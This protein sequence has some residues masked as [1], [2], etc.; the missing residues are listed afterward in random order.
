[1]NKMEDDVTYFLQVNTAVPDDGGKYS[2]TIGNRNDHGSVVANNVEVTVKPTEVESPVREEANVE[3]QIITP[4]DLSQEVDE[5]DTEVKLPQ[6]SVRPK[7]VTV[8][9]GE[10]IQNQIQTGRR[11]CLLGVH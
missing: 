8:V 2:V 9:E 1:M 7:D 10:A 4:K 6:F 3:A 5:C 11:Y